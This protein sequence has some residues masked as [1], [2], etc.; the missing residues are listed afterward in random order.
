MARE[1]YLEG[2]PSCELQAEM[3]QRAIERTER[4]IAA[5]ELSLE[6]MRAKQV[7]RKKELERQEARREEGSPEPQPM[8]ETLGQDQPKPDDAPGRF[9]CGAALRAGSSA[10]PSTGSD[11]PAPGGA[12]PDET[13]LTPAV[14]AHLRDL[15][16]RS[17]RGE[18]SAPMTGGQEKEGA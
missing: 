16:L 17:L 13:P 11:A 15:C 6:Q 4:S 7:A 18:I 10:G 1:I 9:S 2:I 3:V 8:P 5:M 12:K 14:V